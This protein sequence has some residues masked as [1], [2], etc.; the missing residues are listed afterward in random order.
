[1]KFSRWCAPLLLSALVV[2]AS[3]TRAQQYSGG[4]FTWRGMVAPG[5]TLE[6]KG[7][8]G[9]VTAEPA[10]SGQAEVVAVMRARR[11]DPKQV[12]V[13]VVQHAGG[14][15]LCAV[16]P[17]RNAD[18]PNECAPGD[19]G[20]MNVQD[21]DVQ[22][23]FTVKVPPGVSYVGRTVNGDITAQS[24]TGPVELKT[25]N[26]S[27]TLST[28]GHGQ[29]STVNGSVHATLGTAD[30]TGDLEFKT[31]NGSLTVDLPAN[32]STEVRAATVNG[33]ISTDFPLTV[34]GR[35]SPRRLQGTIGAGGRTLALET[36]NGSI[37]LRRH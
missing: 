24:L 7:V 30:W 4:D 37:K 19:A 15:T 32:V 8:N 17:G 6:V 28:S 5:A 34:S 21:N 26:G 1:M 18:K 12:R 33:D 25:V 11:S 20:R 3:P 22:V 2:T 23:T 36:V 9:D 29:A 27:A 31:V 35:F 13:E 14:V 16:Y 10:S